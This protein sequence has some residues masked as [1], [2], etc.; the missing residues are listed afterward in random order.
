MKK[1]KLIKKNKL[2]WGKTKKYIN[3]LI[4]GYNNLKKGY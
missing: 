1:I 3:N 4:E 2:N